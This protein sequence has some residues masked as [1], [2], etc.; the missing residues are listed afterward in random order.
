MNIH[1][2][3]ET[4]PRLRTCTLV[5]ILLSL[6]AC[7]G[8]VSYRGYYPA[9]EDV[10]RLQV[11]EQTKEEVQEILGSP[12]TVSDFRQNHWYYIGQTTKRIAFYETEVLER[13]ILEVAFNSEDRLSSLRILSLDES[14]DVPLEE[15]ITEIG[16]TDPSILRELFGNIGRFD[17]R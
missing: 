10:L 15:R 4:L 9:P 1:T 12:S 7:E 2:K 14:Q 16:G 8:I 5:A 6:A 13:T 11:G 3:R 17:S